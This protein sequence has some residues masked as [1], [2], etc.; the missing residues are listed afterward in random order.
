M[1]KEK[2]K[3]THIVLLAYDTSADGA[4]CLLLELTGDEQS[5]EGCKNYGCLTKSSWDFY[6]H[7]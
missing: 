1:K 2:S 6:E 5:F 7:S 3:K 4:V